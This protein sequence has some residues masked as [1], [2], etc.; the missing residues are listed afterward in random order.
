M[1]ADLQ[2]HLQDPQ[3]ILCYLSTEN[4]DSLKAILPR[5]A[6]GTRGRPKSKFSADPRGDDVTTG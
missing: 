1:Q 2:M 6:S 5:A 3:H 4:E